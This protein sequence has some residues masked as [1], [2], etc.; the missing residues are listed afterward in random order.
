MH[1]LLYDVGKHPKSLVHWQG[2]M[3]GVAQRQGGFKYWQSRVYNYTVGE[4]VINFNKCH[5]A[6]VQPYAGTLAWL[7]LVCN[8]SAQSNTSC[9]PPAVV[10]CLK[11][12]NTPT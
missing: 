5:C 9:F 2:R 12:E 8:A 10:P 1:L 11:Q 6:Q 4:A 3:A 7:S